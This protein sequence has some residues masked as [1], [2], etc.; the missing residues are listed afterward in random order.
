MAV[1]SRFDVSN[2]PIISLAHLMNSA[3]DPASGGSDQLGVVVMTH[4]CAATVPSD[5]INPAAMTR[6]PNVAVTPGLRAC[7]L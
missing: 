6:N 3:R 2:L 4:D 7:L 1:D 5:I